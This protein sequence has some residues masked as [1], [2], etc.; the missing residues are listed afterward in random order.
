MG[1]FASW[2]YFDFHMKGEGF[3]EGYRS[4][5]VN[6]KTGSARKKGIFK[7][8][9]DITGETPNRDRLEWAGVHRQS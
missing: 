5:P 4:V 7:L 3:D 8:L 1:E 9:S 2:G 6:W